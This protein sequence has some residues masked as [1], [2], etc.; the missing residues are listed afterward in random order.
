MI[1]FFDVLRYLDLCLF[2]SS[3]A[4]SDFNIPF[5]TTVCLCSRTAACCGLNSLLSY[6][7]NNVLRNKVAMSCLWIWNPKFFFFKNVGSV[8]FIILVIQQLRTQSRA[9]TGLLTGH[10]TL[11]RHLHLLG[12][13]DSPLCKRC[14]TE[15]E[16]SAHIL[17]ECKA[18]ASL[19]LAYLGSF[20]LEPEDINTY[21]NGPNTFF[22]NYLPPCRS[23]DDLTTLYNTNINV[24]SIY[25][26]A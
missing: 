6:C 13:S 9:V 10:N 2:A 16:T 4:I 26:F 25:C 14:G 20:L 21:T 12:L 1:F 22:S 8:K 18:L 19:R 24:R 17:C 7:Q 11:R 23:L 3:L 15:D 5:Y